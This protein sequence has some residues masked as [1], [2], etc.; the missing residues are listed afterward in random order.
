MPA[1][2]YYFMLPPDELALFRVL[3]RHELTVYPELVPPGFTPPRADEALVPTLEASAYYL[4]AE[5]LGPVIAHP[6]KRGPDRGMLVIEE[7]PS[8]VFHYERSIANEAGELVSGRL[9]AELD[10]TDDPHSKQGKHRALRATFEELH[11][12][13]RKT[14]RRSDPKGFWVGPAAARAWKSEGL[15]L[16]EAGHKG[17]LFGVWR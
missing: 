11:G 16:R 2:L 17:K 8:P 12:W 15:L 5:R 1:T 3:A 9:W 10:V 4:A 13:F 6:L 7:V 14:F